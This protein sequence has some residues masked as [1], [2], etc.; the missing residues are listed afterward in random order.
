MINTEETK[1]KILNV[2]SLKKSLDQVEESLNRSC[3]NGLFDLNEAVKIKKNV[4]NLGLA[5]ETLKKMQD[6]Y[7]SQAT[8]LLD[9]NSSSSL[10]SSLLK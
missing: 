6:L 5:I 8:Q 3:K 4:E 10:S 1:I 7:L 9:S 2:D